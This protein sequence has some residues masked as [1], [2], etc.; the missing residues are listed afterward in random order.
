MVQRPESVT[1]DQI[2]MLERCPRLLKW[3][4]DHLQARVRPLSALYAGVEAGVEGKSAKDAVMAL[5]ASPGLDIDG[6]ETYSAASHL[7]SLAEIISVYL[8]AGGSPWIRHGQVFESNGDL[9]RIVLLDRLSDER[10]MAEIRSWRTIVPICREDR[11]MLINFIAIGQSSDNRR[12]GAWSRG[13]THPRN[14]GLKF[15]KKDGDS[16]GEG[17]ALQWRER[18][19]VTVDRWLSVMQ[20]DRAFD[21]IVSSVRVIIPK[22]REE[23]L[24]DLTRIE[25]EIAEL[26]DNPPM[27]RSGCYGLSPCT[28][29]EV[30]HG[31]A[32]KT[33]S[34][35][36][37]VK[38]SEIAKSPVQNTHCATV[39]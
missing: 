22:R 29:R 4:C 18:S 11:T 30:C 34:E 12:L 8:L 28:F 36:G 2:E 38:V 27:R 17:W 25:R 1:P 9:R 21:D 7:A 37:W 14:F 26:P 3:T 15:K 5:A 33:P 10:K 24:A 31:P 32:F 6:Q 35:Y 19:G 13:W 39:G 23:W 20:R 16:L